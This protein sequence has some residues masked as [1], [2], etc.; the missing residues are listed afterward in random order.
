MTAF[1]DRVAALEEHLIAPTGDEH[2]RRAEEWLSRGNEA[3]ARHALWLA[4][5]ARKREEA[6]DA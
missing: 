1:G 3:A 2:L 4:K 6:D 5:H